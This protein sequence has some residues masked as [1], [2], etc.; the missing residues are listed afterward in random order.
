MN[1]K[2]TTSIELLLLND[3]LQ[4]EA[5]DKEIYNKALHR[6]ISTNDSRNTMPV[7]QASS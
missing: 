4:M 6:I 1:T 3:L 5:I 7:I 2:A